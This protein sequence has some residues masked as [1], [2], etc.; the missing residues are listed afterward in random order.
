MILRPSGLLL[1]RPSGLPLARH[2]GLDP[3]SPEESPSP[4]LYH[5]QNPHFMTTFENGKLKRN[6]FLPSHSQN[7]RYKAIFENGSL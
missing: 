5:S 2:S 4:P 7:T 6:R 1:A 3:E